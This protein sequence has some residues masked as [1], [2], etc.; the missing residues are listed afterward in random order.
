MNEE[1]LKVLSIVKSGFNVFL[2]GAAGTGK[3]F[4]IKAIVKWARPLMNIAVTS[5]TGTSAITV[6]GRTVHSYLGIGLARKDAYQL[7]MLVRGKYPKTIQKLK[8][9]KILII[10]EISMISAEL[11]DK[12][13]EYLQYVRR[14]KDPFGGL[15]IILCGDM[16]Q[17]SPVN[18]EFCFNANV[19]KPAS[20]VCVELKRQMRQTNDDLFSKMLNELR[21]GVCTDETYRALKD[22]RN[23]QFGEI[24]PTILY[25]TNANVDSVNEREFL[26]LCE[27]GAEKRTYETIYS[28]NKNSKTWAESLKIPTSVELCIGAQVVLTVNL[29]VEEGFANGS[30]GM[31]TGFTDDG[32]IVL[33]KNGEQIVIEPWAF[34]EDDDDVT[35][36]DKIWACAIPLK[37]AYALTIHK[38]QS[39][40][41]DAVIV[42]LGP[43]IFEYGQA[44]VA[45]S[46]VRDLKSVKVVNVLRTSFRTHED[47][48]KFY[49]ESC[50]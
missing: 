2:S 23:P 16:C 45:L 28:Q 8:E 5:S 17:L 31:V 25:S 44:Y 42:D 33:F 36:N 43:S 4:T 34:A 15:Q 19:W 18:G 14:N 46:R 7:Y 29:S 9:L 13:S 12:I 27:S 3:S 26:K 37:L 22:C 50:V 35:D 30:R 39:M 32:P 20:F 40:T 11:L 10:D 24:Q 1:Q 6:G 48:V 38:S 47:V 49:N 41:L 21:F